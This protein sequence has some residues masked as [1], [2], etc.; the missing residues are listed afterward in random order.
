MYACAALAGDLL[1]LIGQWSF[2]DGVKH[3]EKNYEVLV[4]HRSNV[5]CN[6][7]R[8]GT[9]FTAGD[10]ARCR[11]ERRS[12]ASYHVSACPCDGAP[13]GKTCV[14][15]RSLRSRRRR[16]WLWRGRVLRRLWLS[17]LFRTIRTV[18]RNWLW[19]WVVLRRLQL[20]ILQLCWLRLSGLW[21]WRRLLPAGLARC[22]PGGDP[23][24]P[25]ALKAWGILIAVC[26]WFASS[27]RGSPIWT[28]VVPKTFLG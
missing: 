6:D 10:A 7:L 23:S 8:D 11:A 27:A 20:S 18:L 21:L 4:S 19:L 26:P 3:K 2:L 14:S 28:D 5:R 9:D 17:G 15:G 24:S 25:L 1:F 12:S 22:P 13:G 16:C